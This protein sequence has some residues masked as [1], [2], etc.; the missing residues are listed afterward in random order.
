MFNLLLLFFKNKLFLFWFWN[1]L[2]NEAKDGLPWAPESFHAFAGQGV[3]S[4]RSGTTVPKTALNDWS[5]GHTDSF[6]QR[7]NL[8]WVPLAT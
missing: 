8:T 6:V 5:S 4:G 3:D 7:F 2:L 1:K